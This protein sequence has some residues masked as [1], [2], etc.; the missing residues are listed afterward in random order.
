GSGPRAGGGGAPAAEAG[1]TACRSRTTRSP[2][3]L[4]EGGN[5]LGAA[6]GVGSAPS[7]AVASSI[8]SSLRSPTR[9]R[10][11]RMSRRG[12]ATIPSASLTQWPAALPPLSSTVTG[13][14]CAGLPVSGCTMRNSHTSP[15]AIR[16]HQYGTRRARRTTTGDTLSGKALSGKALSDE[17]LLDTA[18]SD[19]AQPAT[20]HPTTPH[21]TTPHP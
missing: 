2:A 15:M 17:A 7:V 10:S 21:P 1:C 4:V 6:S 13:T 8:G 5:W 19:T 14:P 3:P 11:L 20:R 9:S 18:L 12:T 16:G